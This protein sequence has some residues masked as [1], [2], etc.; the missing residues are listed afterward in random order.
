MINVVNGEMA[1][2]E[3]KKDEAVAFFKKA[4][5]TDPNYEVC[6]VNHHHLPLPQSLNILCRIV[7]DAR[8]Y[9]AVYELKQ[10][11][12][13]SADKA[14]EHLNAIEWRRYITFWKEGDALKYTPYRWNLLI[15]A[16]V[17]RGLIRVKQCTH[18]HT[19]T[20]THL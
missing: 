19:H 16:L 8:Y 3:N 7:K 18:T 14:L 13:D 9:L 6:G 15:K 17:L 20:H 10:K 1:A 2:F 5:E 12:K 4:L 11:G